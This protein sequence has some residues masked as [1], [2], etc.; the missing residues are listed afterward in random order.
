MKTN[1]ISGKDTREKIVFLL[2]TRA[3][4]SVEDL[5]TELSTSGV[6]V[7]RYLEVLDRDGL[8]E[9]TIQRRE[10]G[11]PVHLYRLT[12]RADELFPQAYDVLSV[13]IL[14]QIEQRFGREVVTS[15][16]RSRADTITARIKPR[17]SGKPLKK[18]VEAFARSFEEMGYLVRVET[19]SAEEYIVVMHHCPVLLIARDFPEVCD[20]DCVI[21]SESLDAEVTR[22]CALSEG[23]SC[24]RFIIRQCLAEA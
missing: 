22:Q 5:A 17:L 9:S 3:P 23:A 11:R 6:N 2:K 19:G 16:L 10:R 18:R 15:I 14:Q 24:C 13:E 1:P 20:G 21:A 4:L 8:V 7:R 12:R